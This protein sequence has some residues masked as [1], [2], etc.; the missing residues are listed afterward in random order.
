VPNWRK[1]IVGDAFELPSHDFNFYRDLFLVWPFLLFSIVG[2]V[3]L[4]GVGHDYRDGAMFVALSL[5]TLLLARER[6]ILIGGALGICAVQ[7]LLSFFLRHNWVGLAVAILTGALFLLLI[8]SL[9]D[10]KP[11][12]QWPRSSSIVTALVSLLSL[13]FS[14]LVFRWIPK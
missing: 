4:F 8:G 2:F 5:V 1:V 11:S 14:F 3:S 9:K 6:F 10:Y 7:S 12:Y 13:G